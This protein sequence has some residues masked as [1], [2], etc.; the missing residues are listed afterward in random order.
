MPYETNCIWYDSCMRNEYFD[1][2]VNFKFW[3]QNFNVCLGLSIVNM[4][5]ILYFD[6]TQS[7]LLRLSIQSIMSLSRK[8]CYV[9]K[10]P[11]KKVSWTSKSKKEWILYI[12][13]GRKF[14][15]LTFR[16]LIS[17]RVPCVALYGDDV[18][19]LAFESLNKAR[20]FGRQSLTRVTVGSA[21]VQS[22]RSM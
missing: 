1:D 3:R 7:K 10:P 11:R 12:D 13:E 19:A 15:Q 8:A 21:V 5:L 14:R 16:L 22:P 2:T 18:V 4:V 6:G 9:S 17:L 20:M